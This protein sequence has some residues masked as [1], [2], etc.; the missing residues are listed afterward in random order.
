MRN[1]FLVAKSLHTQTHVLGLSRRDLA[2]ERI[3]GSCRACGL[4]DNEML[5]LAHT[6]TLTRTLCRELRLLIGRELFVFIEV[7]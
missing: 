2:L 6:H 3:H 5:G 1:V 7:G 4:R